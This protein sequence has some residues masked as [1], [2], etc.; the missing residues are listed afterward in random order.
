MYFSIYLCICL[1]MNKSF[2]VLHIFTVQ[3]SKELKLTVKNVNTDIFV[4][5]FQTMQCVLMS[6]RAISTFPLVW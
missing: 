5:I 4:C 3:Y 6:W 2:L 1:M